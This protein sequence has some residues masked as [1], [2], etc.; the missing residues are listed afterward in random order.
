MRLIAEQLC[1]R[2]GGR[3]LFAGLSFAVEAGE[4]LVV[5]GPNGAG[6]TTLLRTL[7]GFL[8]P[9]A[10]QIRLEGGVADAS[11]A[12]RCHY[13]G[14]ASAVKPSLTVAENATFWGGFLDGAARDTSGRL[15]M[16]LDTFG[17]EALRDIPAGFLSAGQRRR[18]G[19]MRLALA[20][21]PIWLLDEPTASLDE[22]A[23]AKLARVVNRHLGTGG[24]VVAATHVPLGFDRER[25]LRLGATAAASA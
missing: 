11:I 1:A 16:A 24:L 6:K 15:E 7:A 4:A 2:R 8:R 3:I 18:A 13:V 17:L 25:E 22:A 12:E 10:G 5:T 9:E 23:Q 20:E 19:L 14:H 21:R